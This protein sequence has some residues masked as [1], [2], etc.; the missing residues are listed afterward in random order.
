MC[1]SYQCICD[2]PFSQ[3]LIRDLAQHCVPSLSQ[4]HCFGPSLEIIIND[5]SNNKY[6]LTCVHVQVPYV[7]IRCISQCPC[8]NSPLSGFL[9]HVL[10]P[11]K[12]SFEAHY[13][14]VHR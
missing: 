13:R 7:P 14:F 6:K 8:F 12:S 3:V 5:E 2:I 1:R 4:G 10:F 11:E 9:R